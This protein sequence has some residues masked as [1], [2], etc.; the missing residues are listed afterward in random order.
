M[1]ALGIV[2]SVGIVL[3]AAAFGG[4]QAGADQAGANTHPG[5][6]SLLATGRAGHPVSVTVVVPGG[7]GGVVTQMLV[8]GRPGTTPEVGPDESSLPATAVER[9][10]NQLDTT[11]SF[12]ETSLSARLTPPQP[13][14]YPVFAFASRELGCGS[15]N[16]AEPMDLTI[17]RMGVIDVR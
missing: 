12:T 3:S 4:S 9:A 2:Y 8:V 13:G 6:H 11:T 16:M 5:P 10:A 17:T 15:S 1:R 14:T 7:V